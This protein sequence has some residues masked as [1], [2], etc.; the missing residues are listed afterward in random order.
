MSKILIVANSS[1][2]LYNF[3]FELIERLIR[4]GHRI[5]FTVPNSLENEKVQL[6]IKLIIMVQVSSLLPLELKLRILK[7]IP[8]FLMRKMKVI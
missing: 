2:G 6:L 1:G 5:F 3:R 7:L 8:I 4:D